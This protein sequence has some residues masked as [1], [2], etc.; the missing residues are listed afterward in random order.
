MEKEI[1]TGRFRKASKSV[2][3]ERSNTSKAK[4]IYWVGLLEGR[5]FEWKPLETMAFI[6]SRKLV[7]QL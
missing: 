3:N 2:R 4:N 6:F 1:D 7:V 5:H